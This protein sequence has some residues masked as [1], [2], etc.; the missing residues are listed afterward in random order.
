MYTLYIHRPRFAFMEIFSQK[1]QSQLLARFVKDPNV[2]GVMVFGS[3]ASGNADVFSDI[4]L[5]ILT[6]KAGRF[7]RQG[8]HIANTFV[9]VLI[10]SVDKAK[11]YLQADRGAVRRPTSLMLANGKMLFEQTKDLAHLQNL[12]QQNLR[13]KTRSKQSDF[14]MHAYSLDDFLVDLKRDTEKNDALQ[15]ELDAGL[16]INN[17]IEFVLRKHGSHWRQTGETLE[18][19]AKLDAN[20]FHIIKQM[21]SVD[22]LRQRLSSA[23]K[24][25]AYLSKHYACVLP[26]TWRISS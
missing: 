19:L 6:R 9:D 14:L 2:L 11:A 3:Q 5:Y 25:R 26:E 23:K 20:F 1:I 17:A 18:V 22:S 16:F 10:D 4:D 24:L 12:A 13:M 8:F 7:A 15:F 21:S